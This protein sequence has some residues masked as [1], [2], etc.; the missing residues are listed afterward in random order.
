MSHTLTGARTAALDL[1]FPHRQSSH[2]SVAND[3]D[4]PE[5]MADI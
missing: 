5:S 3:L 4:V 1:A 2:A